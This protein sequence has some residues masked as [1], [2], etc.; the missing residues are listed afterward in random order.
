[1]AGFCFTAIGVPESVDIGVRAGSATTCARAEGAATA[2]DAATQNNAIAI[3]LQFF[4][5]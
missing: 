1:L 2:S 5:E 3:C 4:I